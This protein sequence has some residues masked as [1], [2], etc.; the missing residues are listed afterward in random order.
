MTWPSKPTRLWFTCH[1][2]PGI[3]D[4]LTSFRFLS[5]YLNG[6][7]RWPKKNAQRLGPDL[8]VENRKGMVYALCS[9][10][11]GREEGCQWES[12]AHL[13]QPL[14]PYWTTWRNWR[15]TFVTRMPSLLIGH[16]NVSVGA[17]LP[18][19]KKNF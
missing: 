15:R 1:Q 3:H 18:W 16:L 9:I 5:F 6:V 17:F 2:I 10:S 14:N 7:R 8:R 12:K 13:R 4:A 11:N 19:K